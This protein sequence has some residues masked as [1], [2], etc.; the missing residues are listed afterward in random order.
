MN[1]VW[2]K[3]K[4][5]D[6]ILFLFRQKTKANPV[7]KQQMVDMNTIVLKEVSRLNRTNGSKQKYPQFV[8]TFISPNFAIL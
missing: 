6:V 7:Y 4:M 5:D 8:Q 1:G 3:L 2:R